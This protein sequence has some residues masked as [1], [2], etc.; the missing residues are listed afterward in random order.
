MAAGFGLAIKLTTAMGGC[1][2]LERKLGPTLSVSQSVSG[3][4]QKAE[5]FVTNVE[6]DFA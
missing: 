3:L 6:I 5:W 1:V 4:F 2:F